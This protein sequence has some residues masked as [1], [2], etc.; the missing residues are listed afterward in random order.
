METTGLCAAA[1]RRPTSP[2]SAAS[3]GRPRGATPARRL[4]QVD[5]RRGPRPRRRH[6]HPQGP[7]VRCRCRHG[8]DHRRGA[9]ALPGAGVQQRAPRPGPRSRTRE[10]SSTGS[11]PSSEP[12]TTSPTTPFPA[13]RIAASPEV[14]WQGAG[15]LI[16]AARRVRGPAATRWKHQW[17]DT[18]THTGR[19]RSG[20]P[21][22]ARRS[23]PPRSRSRP[24]A[25]WCGCACQRSPST[26][27]TPKRPGSM[28]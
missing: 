26:P 9:R 8:D 28:T 22:S 1:T 10:D 5:A 15:D 16:A 20:E 17:S 23:G 14:V 12:R 21:S 4:R 11:R 2:C 27:L 25:G 7:R 18:Q 19:D 6:V 24:R 13:W 3:P